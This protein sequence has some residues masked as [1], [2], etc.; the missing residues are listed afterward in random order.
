MEVIVCNKLKDH[1]QCKIKLPNNELERQEYANI[2]SKR[3]PWIRNC[4]GFVDCV[5]IPIECS[6]DQDKQ[7]V[8]NNGYHG[9]TMVNNVLAFAPTG[10]VIF[11][12]INHPGSSWHD[13]TVAARLIRWWAKD[14]LG[15][16]CFCVVAII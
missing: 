6:S 2:I 9:D 1:D 4:I 10:K 7:D 14:N 13:S 12:A 11:A 3:E 16:Y 5:A 8:F 15:D